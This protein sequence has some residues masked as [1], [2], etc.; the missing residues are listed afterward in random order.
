MIGASYRSD[1]LAVVVT[2]KV[3]RRTAVAASVELARLWSMLYTTFD[4]YARPDEEVDLAWMPSH[5]SAA[6][7]GRAVL[8]N[9][10]VRSARDRAGN[11]RADQLAKRGAKVN[12]ASHRHRRPH[13]YAMQHRKGRSHARQ[14]AR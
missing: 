3:G 4:D 9:G 6:D 13:G 14:A 1:R 12:E 7:V 8:S 5:T 10:E 11:H 2:C